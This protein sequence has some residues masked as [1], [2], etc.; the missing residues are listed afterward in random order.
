MTQT[1]AL[2][3]LTAPSRIGNGQPD[4][5][6][7]FAACL[8]QW[9]DRLAVVDPDGRRI[10]YREL[11]A[12]V[13][14]RQSQLGDG[15]RLLLIAA[16]NE[17][18][19]L[20]TYLAAIKSG[21]PALLVGHDDRELFE[22]MVETYQ[23][24]VTFQK[25]SAGWRLA[26]RTTQSAHKL[27]DDLSLLLCTSGSTGSPKVA[28]LS[29]SNLQ[30]NAE[31]IAQ[32]LAIRPTDRAVTSLPMQYCYGLSVINSNLAS[33]AALVLTN[34]SVVTTCFWDHVRNNDVSSIHG[35]PHTFD[36]LERSDFAS[37]DMPSLRY[38][39]QAG[40]RLPPEKVKQLASMGRR[41]GW[42]FFVMYGQTEATARMAFLPPDR[43][44]TNPSTIGVPIPGGSFELRGVDGAQ[45]GNEG[46]LVYRGPNVMMGYAHGPSDLCLGR[47][48]HELA[49]GDIA[50][51]THDGLYEVIGRRSRFAK[52]FGLRVDL[53]QVELVLAEAGITVACV[54]RDDRLIVGVERDADLQ[55]VQNIVSSMCK[56]PASTVTV[57]RFDSLP[58]L[59]N[60]KL[61]YSSVAVEQHDERDGSTAHKQHLL[62]RR[63]HVVSLRDEY[64]RIFGRTSV[65][66]D[67]TFLSL[68]GD[69]L[70]Y[71]E[72]SMVLEGRIG[73]LPKNWQELTVRELTEKERELS[74]VPSRRGMPRLFRLMETAVVLRA[75]AIALVVG[76]HMKVFHLEGGAHVLL[77]LAG[78]NFSRFFLRA[79]IGGRIR[80]ATA[81]LLRVA[82][83][84]VIAISTYVALFDDYRLANLTFVNNY[85]RD[86][87]ISFW[88][89]EALM[90]LTIVGLLVFSIKRVAL[91]EQ[92]HRFATALIV[93][94]VAMIGRVHA[95]GVHDEAAR[96]F[97]THNVAWLFVLG[98]AAE[99]AR[100]I[101][102]RL[103]VA[104]AIVLSVPTFFL[105]TPRG[106]LV[107][108][109]LALLVF[110]RA[111]P[112]PSI[113]RRLVGVLAGASL[114]IYLT[115]YAV[116]PE[117]QKYFLPWPS[118]VLTLLV[119]VLFGASVA[120][121][122]RVAVKTAHRAMSF[123]V[124]RR[125][126]QTLSKTVH[127]GAVIR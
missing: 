97:T 26:V 91:A 94:G 38:V 39:T 64:V 95:S 103:I 37:M 49:T 25:G 65:S 15:R 63:A 12:L 98:W 72:A 32:Y 114:Y 77:A 13:R 82:I 58:R 40:G 117:L 22:S 66:D 23:P 109:G 107:L 106:D 116:F 34:H 33:G 50:R 8:E 16:S 21:H 10:S 11:A 42:D 47:T 7:P 79:P 112:V 75:V 78:W 69:S 17:V 18:E 100:N 89:V 36:L 85:L 27:H 125:S 113:A 105:E 14:S 74:A 92:R 61:D 30:A 84:S 122:S 5:G 29:R 118:Y 123:H 76:T 57:N 70:S 124:T 46:E 111:I 19:P 88:F 52:L 127:E 67:D 60:G 83:P 24:D 9:G 115:H 4:K 101:G 121:G 120:A 48:V 104:V 54:A 35:V 71:V 59:A 81:S 56:I 126:M 87:N 6:V 62:G 43:A 68:G 99:A 86:A 41:H 119:G 102:Q 51:L 45:G 31:S 93:L 96:L 20:V 1:E 90:Q 73:Q 28:R 53:E 3:E 80:N 2:D 108:A 44:L 110:V 55:E